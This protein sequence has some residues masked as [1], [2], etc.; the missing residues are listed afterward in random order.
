MGIKHRHNKNW[1]WGILLLAAAA[2]ILANQL[3][4]FI[5]FSFGC[6]VA[7]VLAIVFLS[8]SIRHRKIT[9][10]PFAIAMGYIFLRNQMLVPHMS[11]WALLLA[12]T[13]GSA[14]LGIF[15][16]RKARYKNFVFGGTFVDANDDD[17]DWDMDDED[18]KERRRKQ[19]R[20]HSEAAAIDNDPSFNVNFGHMS[21]YLY[22][23]ALNTVNLSCN[24]GG[25]EIYFDQAQLSPDGATVHVNCKFGG[26]ELFVPGHWHVEEQV[27]CVFGGAEVD[28]RLTAS[29]EDAPRL[30]VVG[31]VAF[32]GI[33]IRRI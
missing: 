22:A 17:D 31:D 14:G 25:M 15:F 30:L 7:I 16:P 6:I 26:V 32:G 2:L 13:L 18:S 11:T 19:S 20:I 24:F 8:E 21:R 9:P 3:G 10:L 29:T 5:Q 12:A 33:E 1:A 23:D 28:R 4:F 27:G